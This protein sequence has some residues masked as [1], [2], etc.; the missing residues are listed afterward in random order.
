MPSSTY[1]ARTS[2]LES[3]LRR[4]T[5]REYP[6]ANLA[7]ASER[8]QNRISGLMRR[9]GSRSTRA[10]VQNGN[11]LEELERLTRLRDSGTLDEEEFQREKRLLL[12]SSPAATGASST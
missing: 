10:P 4:Q 2:R 8:W 5:A 3:V 7:E 12:D 6:N 11:R 1:G 9:E